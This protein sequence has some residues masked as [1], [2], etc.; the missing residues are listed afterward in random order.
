MFA[1]KF[2][3][4][5]VR[6]YLLYKQEVLRASCTQLLIKHTGGLS[7]LSLSRNSHV[8]FHTTRV[9]ML[10]SSQLIRKP[11]ILPFCYISLSSSFRSSLLNPPFTDA[12]QN[13]I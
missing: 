13:V 4:V 6:A 10:N 12:T 7:F 11:Q 2:A 8:L 1:R 9:V 3:P 5:S